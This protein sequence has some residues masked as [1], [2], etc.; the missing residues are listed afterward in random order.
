MKKELVKKILPHLYAVLIF[1]VVS[2]LFC[3]PALEGNVLSQDDIIKWK[4]VAQNAFEYKEKNG[5]FPLWNT[6]LFSGMPNY[7]IAV[8]GK[9]V[10]PDIVKI[11][12][13]GMPKPINFFFV[14]CLCF[15]I[16]AMALGV[17]SI[18]G[19]LGALAFSFST[20]NT[21]LV[22]AGHETQMLA[23]AFMPLVLAGM[24]FTFQKKY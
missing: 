8:Q 24:I 21:V 17:R 4:G 7:Q 12:T 15:Y 18:V 16:L 9:S 23:T 2:M 19:I 6:N 10:L 20:Y 5:H 11:V 3:K 14:A 13:L 1:L 22:F